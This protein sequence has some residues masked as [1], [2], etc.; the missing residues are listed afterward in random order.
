MGQVEACDE[1]FTS[2]AGWEEPIEIGS[3]LPP[4][5]PFDPDL[6]PESLR[7]MVTDVADRMQ[8]P[9]D[10][11]AVVAVATLAGVCG[12][13]AVIQPKALDDSWT[14]VPNLWGA[15]VAE[16]GMM[17]SPVI[18]AVTSAA[19]LELAKSIDAIRQRVSQTRMYITKFDER[20]ENVVF[21]PGP[22]EQYT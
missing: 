4:V 15:I 6:L 16:A 9:I 17:K 11:P 21:A 20:R 5:S 1:Q 10:F 8:V 14:V 2:V 7:P 18:K 12:R 19:A 3:K 13:R 22:R